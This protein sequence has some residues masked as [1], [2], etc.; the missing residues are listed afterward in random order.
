MKADEGLINIKF[1]IDPDD[2]STVVEYTDDGKGL[3]EEEILKSAVDKGLVSEEASSTLSKKQI[4]SLIF[5]PGFSTKETSDTDAGRGV[6]M[7]V[8]VD[9]V[10]KMGGRVG[11][12]SADNKMFKFMMK[13]PNLENAEQM[14]EVG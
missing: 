7:D 9:L 3:I 2:K 14:L 1:S 4:M 11:I 6:G 12:K 5:K 13:I 8:I 10:K